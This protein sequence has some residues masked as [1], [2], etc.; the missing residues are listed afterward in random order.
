MIIITGYRGEPHVYSHHERNT[1]IG[2]FGDGTHILDVGSNLAATVI[3]NNEVQIADGMMVGE[4]CTAEVPRGTTES[5]T[6]EN[7]AQGMQRI[8]LIVARYTK[9]AGTAVEN[10]SLVVIKGTSAASDP[11][12]PSYNQGL[13]ADGDSPVDFPLYRV[14]LSGISITSVQRLVDVVSVEGKFSDANTR[15]DGI[16]TRID[17]IDTSISAIRTDMGGVKA[18]A[19]IREGINIPAGGSGR[20]SETVIDFSDV[21]PSN[22]HLVGVDVTLGDF[23]L[24]YVR[25]GNPATWVAKLW[26]RAIRIDNNIASPWN[27]YTM[28]ATLFYTEVTP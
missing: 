11:A 4:G 22:V 1:N 26:E 19:V 2:V 28:Y 13:I 9:T 8:D 18:K 6:I 7:G 15:M 21:L 25:D 16:D 24:P 20:I 23:R 3:S 27:N 10:M 17:G 12:V 5:L 14:N